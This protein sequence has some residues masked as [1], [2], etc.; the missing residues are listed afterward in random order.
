VQ[1]FNAQHPLLAAVSNKAISAYLVSETASRKAMR[2]PP[3]SS[4]AQVSGAAS[5][6]I[7]LQLE[8]QSGVAVSSDNHG[9]YLVRTDNWK[10]LASAIDSLVLPKSA[11]YKMVV[12]PPRV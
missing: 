4:L 12:D 5:S 7:A 9:S 2:M 8:K 3:Y 11:R 1:T 6:E 10:R